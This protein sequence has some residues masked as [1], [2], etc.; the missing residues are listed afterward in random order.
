MGEVGD[1]GQRE[2]E[3][4]LNSSSKL[5]RIDRDELGSSDELNGVGKLPKVND[6]AGRAGHS[7]CLLPVLWR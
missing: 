1:A 7:L 5:E 2:V 3:Q 4:G 6:E